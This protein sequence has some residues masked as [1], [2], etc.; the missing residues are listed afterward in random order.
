MVNIMFDMLASQTVIF[1]VPYLKKAAQGVGAKLY[2]IVKEKFSSDHILE[3]VFKKFEQAPDDINTQK[4][5]E[6][7]LQRTIEVDSSFAGKLADTINN[8]AQAN[9]GGIHQDTNVTGG[10][11]KLIEIATIVST[12][13]NIS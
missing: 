12:N 11:G 4:T 10:V 13:V 6:S 8:N 2:E 9:I 7:A 5:I 3:E 1:L